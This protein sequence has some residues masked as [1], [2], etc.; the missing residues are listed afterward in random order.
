MYTIHVEFLNTCFAAVFVFLVCR[1]MACRK[2][3]EVWLQTMQWLQR[4][5]TCRE[6]L[7]NDTKAQSQWINGY[8]PISLKMKAHPVG[9]LWPH[10]QTLKLN[11]CDVNN[12]GWAPL[13]LNISTL[14]Q[15]KNWPRIKKQLTQW[16]I[17]IRNLDWSRTLKINGSNMYTMTENSFFSVMSIIQFENHLV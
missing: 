7:L 2:G 6:S 10:S 12:S 1:R 13:A 8:Q 9:S 16:G 3:G 17:F 5:C 4:L 11:Q 14:F 15:T